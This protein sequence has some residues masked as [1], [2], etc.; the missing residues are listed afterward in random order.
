M[1][2]SEVRLFELVQCC[3]VDL[4][5][6]E[7]HAFVSEVTQGSNNVCIVTNEAGYAVGHTQQTTEVGASAF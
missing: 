5:P 3:L 4:F 2:S 7:F 6:I 1:T